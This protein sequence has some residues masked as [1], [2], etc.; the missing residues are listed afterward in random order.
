MTTLISSDRKTP[1][2]LSLPVADQLTPLKYEIHINQRVLP[3]S[4]PPDAIIRYIDISSIDELGR[5]AEPVE[6]QFDRSP[7]RARR[8]PS[9][10]DTLVSTVRTYLRAIAYIDSP[11]PALVCSTGFAV[12]TPG[13]RIDG[14]F[15][16]YWMRS[17]P[18][19]DEI[20]ARSVG[21]S[22]PAVNA[23][24]LGSLP[25]PALPLDQQRRIANFLDRKTATIDDLIRKKERQMVLLQEK[26]Q[27]LVTQA[28]TRG[29]DPN[30]AM[31]DSGIAWIGQMPR[32]WKLLP[33]RAV[34]VERGEYNSG[35]KTTNFL[36]VVK[37]VGVIP[38]EE[39]EA[40][41]N[42]KSDEVEKYKVIHPGDIVVNRMNVIFGS[43]GLSAHFGCSSIEYY[44]LRGRTQDVDTRFYGHLFRSKRVL[45]KG[46][47]ARRRS[48]RRI[49][50]RWMKASEDSS[51][52]S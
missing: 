43:V 18:V 2:A 8:I 15:L 23:L 19:V 1:W 44:V 46:S 52:R 24:E 39:R 16:A 28:V 9:H 32:A 4:T 35:P 12:L 17:D 27:V 31:K 42:K 26:R 51:L 40:S 5:I 13:R 14:R 6:L 10:G 3:E 11:P 50:P 49:M 34:L 48:M 36:S 7:S 41:G 38:Y 20:C 37:D 30:V 21:V 29:L 33:L 47:Q 22:Y 45:N 25:V